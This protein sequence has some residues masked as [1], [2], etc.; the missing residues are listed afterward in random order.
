MRSSRRSQFLLRTSFPSANSCNTC[1]CLLERRGTHRRSPSKQSESELGGGGKA[2]I[3]E[4]LALR[5]ADR[6]HLTVRR[7]SSIGFLL[8]HN[9]VRPAR[10]LTSMIFY[11]INHFFKGVVIA[12]LAALFLCVATALS[13]LESLL[14]RV[15]NLRI[16]RAPQGKPVSVLRSEPTSQR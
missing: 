7:G 14:P 10:C 13:F 15:G 4:P 6:R 1:F 2:V 16:R 12:M 11:N 8:W 9:L 3:L 5:C